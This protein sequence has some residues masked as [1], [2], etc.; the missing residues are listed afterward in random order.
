MG[1]RPPSD[2]HFTVP[3]AA[4]VSINLTGFGSE[5]HGSGGEIGADADLRLETS[6]LEA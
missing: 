4:A 3:R 6:K 5:A 1:P 2:I